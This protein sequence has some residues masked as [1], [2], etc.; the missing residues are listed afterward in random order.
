MADIRTLKLA[1]LADTKDFIQGLDKADKET[2]S[3][4]NKLDDAL[5]KGAAAFLAV[6]AAAG[7]MAIKIGIDAVKAA[8]EDEKAQASLAQTL[9]NTTQATEAQIAATEDFIDKTA[10]ATGVADDQLRPSLQRLLV[11][12]KNLTEAQKLQSLALDISA[13]TGKDLLSVSDALAKASDGNFKALKNLGVELKTN[14]TTTKKLTVS[15]KDLAEA[16][17]KTESASLRLQSAQ[18]RLSKAIS[19]NGVDSLEA[20][21]AQ[22][23]L[24]TAQLAADK[25]SDKLQNTLDKQGKTIKVTKE[26]TISFDEAVRQLT[27]NFAGQAEI[28]ANTFAGRMGKLKV[29]IDEAKEQLGTALL[30]L[31]ERFAKF[32]TDQLAPALQGLVDGLTAKGKQGLTRAFYDAGTG[33]VT[34]GYDMDNVQGQAYLLGEQLRRTTQLLVDMLDK[35][36]GAAEGEGFK[37]LLTVITSV[38]SGLERAISLYNSLPDFGKLLINPLG[39]LAPLA[40]AAGQ[41]PGVIK[42][43]GTTVNNYNIKGAI[44]PQ[45]TARTITKVQNTA[46]KTTGIKPFNFGFR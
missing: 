13:G 7:A 43:Q 9:R 24:E 40:G 17:L 46:N 10:R 5:Q 6:G 38:I 45:A 35:V 20:K 19:K 44:D 37:K 14:T 23:S 22:N 3:F 11:S 42:G 29:A 28:A 4:S 27:E 32:A 25:S 2:R 31:L 21:K 26:E 8:I 18:E 39:Q 36:T 15:K 34:F 1:L 16:E 30:P 33:A 41:V 12:T